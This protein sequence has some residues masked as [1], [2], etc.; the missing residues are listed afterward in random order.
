V[1]IEH[2]PAGAAAAPSVVYNVCLRYI[3][4]LNSLGWIE[5]NSEVRITEEGKGVF[6][7]LLNVSEVRA[8]NIGDDGV[9]PNNLGK[10]KSTEYSWSLYIPPTQM[11]QSS[12]SVTDEK[13]QQRFL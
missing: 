10:K 9:W 6:A 11:K 8:S 5:V 13:Q 7:K 1:V 12:S 3:R 2:A 4:I